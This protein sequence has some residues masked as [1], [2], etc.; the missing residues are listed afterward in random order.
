L[1]QDPIE[2]WKHV[3]GASVHFPIALFIVGLMFDYGSVLFRRPN[4][5]TVGFWCL[6]AGAI[7][8]VPACVSGLA[9]LYGWLGVATSPDTFEGYKGSNVLLMFGHRNLGLT[10]TGIAILLAIWRAIRKDELKKT[11]WGVFLALW[12]A[13]TLSIGL[14]G[15]MGAY[16]RG[17]SDYANFPKVAPSPEASPTAEGAPAPAP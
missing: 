10:G 4:W 1:N 5:R 2:F 15:Y 16:V 9:G 11:E 8:A 17:M 3:H 12:L 14:A 7:V 13:A 6:I